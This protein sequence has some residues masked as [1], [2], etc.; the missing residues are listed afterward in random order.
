M[1]YCNKICIWP[2]TVSLQCL[3][4]PN[5]W[6]LQEAM[7]ESRECNSEAI[8]NFKQSRNQQS[9]RSIKLISDLALGV[10]NQHKENEP[11]MKTN[12]EMHH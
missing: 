2:K 8:K 12:N 3:A 4:P 5:W 1:E 7:E 6:D 11:I 10:K 9:E